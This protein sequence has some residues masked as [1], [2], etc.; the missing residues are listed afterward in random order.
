MVLFIEM[1]KISGDFEWK[2][3]KYFLA[4]H[5]N[6]EN[7]LWISSSLTQKLITSFR[8][9]ISMSVLE[10]C[11]MLP[12]TTEEIIELINEKLENCCI[13]PESDPDWGNLVEK[14][15]PVLETIRQNLEDKELSIRYMIFTRK[16][17]SYKIIS[18]NP[19]L[20][21]GIWASQTQE[22]IFMEST[23]RERP[24]IQFDSFLLRNIISQAANAPVGYPEIICPISYS[25]ST[26]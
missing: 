1:N 2:L 8:V 3:Y 10:V 25:F 24:S 26:F 6:L 13:M 12:E 11:D 23:D 21:K 4:H 16:K 18:L 5:M 20:V 17:Q 15:V 22:T 7:Y 14:K 19:E 9:A